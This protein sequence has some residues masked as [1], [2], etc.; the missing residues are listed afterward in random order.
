MFVI[1]GDGEKKNEYIKLADHYKLSN[2]IDTPFW[3]YYSEFNVKESIWQ[4]Y[5]LH[6][7]KH[8]TTLP[9]SLWA[10]LA[11]YYDEFTLYNQYKHTL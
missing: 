5:R 3:K 1:V 11:L 9:D 10:N 6:N 2:R 7:N 8:T 4:A